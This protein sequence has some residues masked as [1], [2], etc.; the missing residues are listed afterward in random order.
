MED[1]QKQL[2]EKIKTADTV[3]L[4]K[5]AELVSEPYDTIILS[6]IERIE[7]LENDEQRP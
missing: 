7:R 6:L 1:L 2:I 5:L 4:R 3:K